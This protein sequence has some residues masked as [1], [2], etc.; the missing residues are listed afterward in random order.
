MAHYIREKKTLKKDNIENM[1]KTH[2][3]TEMTAADF[4]FTFNADGLRRQ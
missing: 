1:A 4:D 3:V 2:D